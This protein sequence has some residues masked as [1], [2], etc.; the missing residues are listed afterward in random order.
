METTD[1]FVGLDCRDCEGRFDP[2][3][4]THRCPDCA[5]ILDPAYDYNAINLTH[6]VLD[7]RSGQSMWRF[8][9]LLPFPRDRAVTLEEGATPLVSCPRLAQAADVGELLVKDEGRNPTG[10]FTDRGASVSM[11]AAR[12]SCADTVALPST[13]NAGQAV[14]AYAARAGLDAQVFLP[15]RSGFVHK[16]M[17]NIHGADMTV[18]EGRIDD[19]VSAYNDAATANEWHPLASFQTP[20]RH[21]GQKTMAFELVQTLGWTTPDAIIHPTGDGVGLVGMYKGV[22]ELQQLDLIDSIP[23]LYTAQSSGCAPIVEA[24]EAGESRHTPWDV[25]DTICGDI[26][27]P[28]PMASEWVLEAL[29]KSGG[30]AVAIDDDDILD[31]A[32]ELAATEGVESSATLGAAAGGARVLRERGDLGAADQIVLVNT[33]AGA[34]DADVLRS[35]LMSKGI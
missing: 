12:E 6:D 14:S 34:T 22:W 1:A 7:D 16:A 23:A 29:R 21:E 31:A 20:Y 11:T 2:A 3:Q 4:A 18:V 27:V 9:D 5:G 28:N 13:G 25:P 30:G 10:S 26:E 35:H 33:G 8:R 24:F 15:T 32:T 19:A 17:I